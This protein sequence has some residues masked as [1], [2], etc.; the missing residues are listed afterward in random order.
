MRHIR[1]YDLALEAHRSGY[2]LVQLV[3]QRLGDEAIDYEPVVA[4]QRRRQPCGGA[5]NGGA[6]AEIGGIGSVK[7]GRKRSGLD[8]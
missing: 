7:E 2:K 5:R 6:A 8:T 4:E 3:Q 1:I